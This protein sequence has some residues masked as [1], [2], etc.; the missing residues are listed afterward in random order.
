MYFPISNVEQS[1]NVFVFDKQLLSF[2]LLMN[3]Q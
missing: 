2:L 1:Y 3:K